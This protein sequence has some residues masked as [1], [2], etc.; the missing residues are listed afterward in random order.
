ME[1]RK[2]S[3]LSVK[4]DGSDSS[5]KVGNNLILE[6]IGEIA[7]SEVAAPRS[8]TAAGAFICLLA[9]ETHVFLSEVKVRADSDCTAVRR[10]LLALPGVKEEKRYLDAALFQVT[11]SDYRLAVLGERKNKERFVAVV[12]VVSSGRVLGLGEEMSMYDKASMLGKGLSHIAALPGGQN[13]E[14]DLLTFSNIVRK[15]HV[16]EAGASLK[17]TSGRVQ[18]RNS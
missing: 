2:V 16:E 1:S 4:S 17:P 7:L 15:L 3:S 14:A 6:K 10:A 12:E 5:L 9:G 8:L 11:P 18:G 13:G